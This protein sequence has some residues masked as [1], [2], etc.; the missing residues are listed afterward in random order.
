MKP[1]DHRSGGRFLPAG[2]S[3]LSTVSIGAAVPVPRPDTG[4]LLVR[5]SA[6]AVNNTDI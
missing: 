3:D 1:R 4:E 2:P 6:A 5:M